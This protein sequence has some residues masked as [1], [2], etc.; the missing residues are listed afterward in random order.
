MEGTQC[1]TCKHYEVDNT[2]VF[3]PNG[4]PL[5]ILSGVELHPEY[6]NYKTGEPWADVPEEVK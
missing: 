3:F 2:C 6:R 5:N 1:I 4:I